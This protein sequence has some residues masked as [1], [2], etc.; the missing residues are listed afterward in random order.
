MK[1]RI[2]INRRIVEANKK[3]SQKTGA[4]VDK[5]A[6][7]VNTYLG[8]IYA[9]EVE[10]TARCRLVQ[11]AQ[12]SSCSGATIWLECDWE[13][14]IIDGIPTAQ[15]H[16]RVMKCPDCQSICLTVINWVQQKASPAEGPAKP[17]N[18]SFP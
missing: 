4:I 16:K 3:L 9:K 10:M 17:G 12:N 15:L 5:P 8:S 14:L 7:T 13:S 2:Y 1:A 11:D 6:I 18:S